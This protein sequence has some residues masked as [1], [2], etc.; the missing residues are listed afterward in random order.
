MVVIELVVQEIR[1]KLEIVCSAVSL[2]GSLLQLLFSILGFQKKV[3]K[4]LCAIFEKLENTTAN[5]PS[6]HEELHQ[7]DT[8]AEFDQY[9]NSTDDS[10]HSSM[11]R[12]QALTFLNP[13]YIRGVFHTT[14]VNFC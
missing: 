13:I 12:K 3:L 1:V 11:V 8:M 2:P 7:F 9:E 4:L 14:L 10:K 6:T 5:A